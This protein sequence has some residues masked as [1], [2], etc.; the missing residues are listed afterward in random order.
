MMIMITSFK[1]EYNAV[2]HPSPTVVSVQDS[3]RLRSR[4]LD[5]VG[6]RKNGPASRRHARGEGER[7]ELRFDCIPFS[8][9]RS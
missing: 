1:M 8:G 6:P 7:P 2:N 5:V 4:R 9:S 3:D